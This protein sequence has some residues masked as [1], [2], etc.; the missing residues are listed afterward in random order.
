MN[1]VNAMPGGAPKEAACDRLSRG[2]GLPGFVGDSIGLPP[3]WMD[4]GAP[5]CPSFRSPSR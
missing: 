5:R 4:K 2:P 1:S 3:E